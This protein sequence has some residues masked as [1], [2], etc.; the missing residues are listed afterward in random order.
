MDL[1]SRQLYS[2]QLY[3]L[4][5]ESLQTMKSARVLIIGTS[6]PFVEIMKNLILMG[7]GEITIA[8]T[9]K[10]EL[11]DLETNYYLNS[12]DI[13][14][15]F[16]DVVG[17]RMQK[18]NPTIKIMKY[19]NY[20]LSDNFLK[21][22]TFVIVL[23][24][25]YNLSVK[26][27]SLEIPHI[28][29]RTSGCFGYIFADLINFTSYNPNGEKNKSGLIL[30]I[31]NNDNIII[32]T[33]DYHD[34]CQ[35]NKIKIQNEIYTIIKILSPKKFVIDT[36]ILNINNQLEKYEEIKISKK[37]TFD[38]IQ[39]C[40]NKLKIVETDYINYGSNFKKLNELY[41]SNF[42]F[43]DEDYGFVFINSIIGGIVAQNVINFV[44]KCGTPI[45]QFI[46]YNYPEFMQVLNK[47]NTDTVF[48]VGAGALGCEHIKNL[49][50]LGVKNIVITDFDRIE[51]SNLSR[52]FLFRDKD[53]N[54]FKSD[55]AKKAILKMKPNINV[56]SLKLK[57][58]TDTESVFNYKFYKS[59]NCIF[60][61]LDNIEARKYVDSKC[62]DY[63]IPLFESGTIGSKANSQ[64]IIPSLTESYSSSVTNDDST[65]PLCTI[66]SF[67]YLPEHSVTWAK[68][69]FAELFSQNLEITNNL[70][71][72]KIYQ[73]RIIDDINSLIEKYPEN[74]EEDKTKFWSKTRRFPNLLN[75]NNTT[76]KKD[77]ID[78]GNL[79]KKRI[80]ENSLLE[81]FDKDSINLS[82]V[83]F[84][85]ILTNIRNSIYS[86]EIIDEFTVKGIA[87]KI[88]P[89]LCSTTSVI[90]GLVMIEYLRYCLKLKT[91]ESYTNNYVNLSLNLY[92][93][94][95]PIKCKD[96]WIKINLENLTLEDIL[97]KIQNDYN[98]Y[99]S[100][101][102]IND[103]N[104][105]TSD[106]EYDL[107]YL[108]SKLNITSERIF[109]Y[110]I[111]DNNTN[112]IIRFYL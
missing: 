55:R 19:S 106:T 103:K 9:R 43:K 96:E 102:I 31:I 42:E 13:G 64:T 41:K 111:L 78:M 88:I 36:K 62:V 70:D 93:N 30:N 8:D 11:Y 6:T 50:Y 12:N 22:F 21:L 74:Y 59:V 68:E 58:A 37:F 82:H 35:G 29:T 90:S 76:Y 47:E 89:A 27:H 32:E 28:I 3:A 94:S 101:I 57:V 97:V 73:E 23:K 100:T 1:Y 40:N 84:L 95:I 14:K 52:Q 2:R 51:K 54:K 79:I 38:S 105:Y 46:I 34:L 92:T 48:I 83:E 7:I 108:K 18:L 49:A 81:D 72:E 60:N 15:D 39:N 77:F 45:N 20:N 63:D 110:I 53:I 44:N 10:I 17:F 85:T 33:V 69:L 98:N 86:I 61:A 91:L 16:V 67:P 26:L 109:G 112:D 56:K 87:G 71:F 107:I 25:N 4:G 80:I 5:K 66:K 65:I 99:I 104:V 75:L 24:D